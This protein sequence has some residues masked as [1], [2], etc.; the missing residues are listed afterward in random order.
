M[1]SGLTQQVIQIFP[2]EY[3][4]LIATITA[5]AISI[6]GL[7]ML[8]LPFILKWS[9]NKRDATIQDNALS[10]EDIATAVE[11]AVETKLAVAEKGRVTG[12]LASWKFKLIY[13][14]EETKPMIDAEITRLETELAQYA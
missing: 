14:T 2:A 7:V 1:D 5:I 6:F 13:A 3:Q 11:S 12:E 4:P 10:A 9:A 8:F